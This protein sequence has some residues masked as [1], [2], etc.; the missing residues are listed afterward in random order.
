MI[1]NK[2]LKKSHE[3]NNCSHQTFH[4][5]L[6]VSKITLCLSF[7]N[8][9]CFSLVFEAALMQN[10]LCSSLFYWHAVRFSQYCG[11]MDW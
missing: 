3:L 2:I 11:A 9:T 6:Y 4:N 1:Q 5:N 10:F 7:D 8:Y